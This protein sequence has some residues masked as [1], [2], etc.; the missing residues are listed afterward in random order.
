M[1]GILRLTTGLILVLGLVVPA[2]AASKPIVLNA[3]TEPPLTAPDRRGFLDMIAIEAFRRVG[4]ELRLVHLPAE[5][6]LLNANAGIEDGEL[7]RIGGLEKE[8]PNLRRVPEKIWEWDFVAFTRR[9]DIPSSWRGVMPHIAGHIKGWKIYEANLAGAARVTTVDDPDQLFRM[10]ARGRVD[11]ALYERWMG[12]AQVRKRKLADV[13]LLEPPL[14][15]R[16]MFMY[17]H[18]RH[19]ALVPRLAEAL[20]ALKAEGFYQRA[21]REK[22]APLMTER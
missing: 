22:L 4:H 8:Y 9:Q 17:L 7:I 16:E 5:R 19:A 12:L 3:A 10:F 14:V 13:H 6:A 2:R 11:L 18:K 15:R 21:F 1:N 20:R